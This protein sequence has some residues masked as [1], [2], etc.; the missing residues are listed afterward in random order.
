MKL[1]N[2]SRLIPIH[3]GLFEKKHYRK[4]GESIWLFGFLIAIANWRT[5][6]G[7]TSYK[8][9]REKFGLSNDVAVWRWLGKL[10]KGGYINYRRSRYS[11]IYKIV[12]PR[13]QAM[14]KQIADFVEK[15]GSVDLT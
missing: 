15:F 3:R 11:I 4:M 14:F 2:K 8:V 6:E 5:W 7:E 1:K 13:S 12:P 10:R 9:I